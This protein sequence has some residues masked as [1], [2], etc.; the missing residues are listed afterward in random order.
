MSKCLPFRADPAGRTLRDQYDF[1]DDPSP[2]QQF[3]RLSRLD[4]GKSLRDQRFDLLLSKQLQQCAQILS[5]ECRLEPLEPLDA[6]GNHAFVA[7]EN[8]AAKNVQRENAQSLI[9]TAT[10]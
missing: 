1:P 5:K 6:V 7:G 10:A 3:M 8:P 9:P 2:A 4:Q